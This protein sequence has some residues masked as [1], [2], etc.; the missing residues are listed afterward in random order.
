VD[1]DTTIEDS[2]KLKI[3]GINSDEIATDCLEFISY[4][5]SVNDLVKQI[6][7]KNKF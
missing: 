2:D 1:I 6:W 5:S 7:N 3:D 4:D